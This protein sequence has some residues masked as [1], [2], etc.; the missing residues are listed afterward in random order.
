MLTFAVDVGFATGFDADEEDVVG[1]NDGKAGGRVDDW[2]RGVL[3]FALPP[4]VTFA[5]GLGVGAGLFPLRSFISG[6]VVRMSFASTFALFALV[7]LALGLG[8]GAAF[9]PLRSSIFGDV[10]RMSFG[11]SFGERGR[12]LG[13]R[14]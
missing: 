6:D 14:S 5:F 2:P 10:V 12:F 4:L 1:G 3:I 9:F 11:S 8:I 13:V 7:T